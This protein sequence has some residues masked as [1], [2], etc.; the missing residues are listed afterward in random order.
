MLPFISVCIPAYKRTHYLKRLLDSLAEQTYRQFEIVVTDDTPGNEVQEL[1]ATY[2]H[3]PIQ[4]Y[5]NDTALGT[6]ENWNE[7]IRRAKADW[8]KI[9]HDDDWFTGK[10]SLGQFADAIQANPDKAFLFAAYNNVH[11]K[12]GRIQPMHVAPVNLQLLRSNHLYLLRENYV[13]NPSCTLFKKSTNVVFDQRLK[14]V[15]DFEFYMR[16][17]PAVHNQFVYIDKALI[18]VSLN[19]TQVTTYTFR[20]NKVEIPENHLMLEGL[21]MEALLNIA[22]YDYFWRLYR[23]L[24]IKNEQQVVEDGYAKPLHPVLKSM[25]RWQA[26]VPHRLLLKGPFSKSLMLLHYTTHVASLK[27]KD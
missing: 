14:Y 9:M 22:A 21:G 7:G 26:K 8:I 11:E 2:G 1:V 13:G 5:K 25:I 10:D 15:V 27:A 18:N 3:L 6:P 24:H 12:D 19:D 4:Y 16:Y 20:V 17:L 23:N